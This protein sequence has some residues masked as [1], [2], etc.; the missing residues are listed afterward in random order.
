[1][2]LGLGPQRVLTMTACCGDVY[3]HPRVLTFL[4]RGLNQAAVHHAWA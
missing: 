4:L 3:D 1:V 2:R